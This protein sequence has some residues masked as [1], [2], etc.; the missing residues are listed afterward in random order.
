MFKL[1]VE[2]GKYTFI[3]NNGVVSVLRHN[4][5][6]KDASGDKSL[7]ALLHHVEELEQQLE[8]KGTNNA[9]TVTISKDEYEDLLDKKMFL[10]AL[11]NAGVDNWSGYGYAYELLAEENED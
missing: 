9:D 8:E 11:Q 5:A 1:E 10:N 7:L 3:N 4:E 2:E 6:W